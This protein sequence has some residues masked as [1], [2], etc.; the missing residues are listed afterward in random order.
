MMKEQLTLSLLWLMLP[1]LAT[2]QG[3]PK[4]PRALVPDDRYKADVL[5]VVAHPDDDTTIGG[6]L[7]RLA[8]EHKRV[9]V[10]YG[11]S[12]DGGGDQVGNEAGR[13][14]GQMRILESR[15]AIEFLGI[16][17]VWFLGGSDTPGQNVLWALDHWQHGRSLDEVVRLVRL[18][19][20]QVILT[21]LP[22]SV[23]GENHSDHQAAGVLATEAFDL[24]GDRTKFTE[25]VSPAR[26]RTGMMNYTEGLQ[27]WQPQKI[28]YFTDAFDNFIPYWHDPKDLSPFRKN[29]LDGEGPSYST[30]D[31]SSLKH[32]SYARLA[33]KELSFYGT[34]DAKLGQRAIDKDNYQ[35]FEF[36]VRFIFGKSVVGGSATGDIL[37]GTSP[38]AVPFASVEGYRPARSEGI[39]ISIG[40][41]WLFYKQFWRAHNLDHLATLLPVPEVGMG[42]G[43]TLHVPLVIDNETADSADV[44]L[45]PV[46]P[47]GWVDQS[48]Y[49][50]FEIAHG[51]S[52][53]LLME[54]V[55]PESGKRQW[56]ELSWNAESVGRKVGTIT[57][58]VYLGKG[59]ALPQ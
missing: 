27:P 51:E 21:W 3:V 48:R 59:S 46:L 33:A 43:G 44:V 58:R 1:L 22:E 8:D 12:G 4:A 18:T 23:A 32:E 53:P 19:R 41:P 30:T 25:Q 7:A 37:E 13:T 49:R 50:R 34:Q 52:Y 26:D 31:V 28:Y 42:F 38:D 16:E 6:Y 40:D 2:A 17:N 20:P 36:P 14:L 11:S 55:A 10:I 29:F 57:L 45:T 47:A 35:D 56:Q 39:S 5:L 54:V 15:K 9:A 24:A